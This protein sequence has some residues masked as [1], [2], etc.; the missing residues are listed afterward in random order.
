M[1]APKSAFWR[2]V[3]TLTTKNLTILYARHPASTIYT[4][5]LLPIILTVYLGIGRNLNSPQ[6]DYGIAEPR[7]VRSL[8]DGL[9][10]ADGSA[11][12][13]VVFVNNGLAGG[14]IGQ[15]VRGG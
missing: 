8:R 15:I 14:E 3:S 2:Q 13:T 11:R 6:N 7:P 12:D 5:L 4:A 9:A 1:A 10:A